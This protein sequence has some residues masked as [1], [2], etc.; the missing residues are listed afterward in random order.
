[1]LFGNVG[2][3]MEYAGLEEDIKACIQ[4]AKKHDLSLFEKGTHEIDGQRLFVNIVE[5]TTTTPKERPWEAHKEYLD[6]HL[7]LTGSERIDLNFIE[8][9]SHKTYEPETDFLPMEGEADRYVVLHEG[10]FLVCGIHDGHRTAIM[11]DKPEAVKKA[12]FKVRIQP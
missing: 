1:M 7:M 9:L 3:V 12:I 10:E 2:H 11:V 5:Y 4:Y 8:N 6:I